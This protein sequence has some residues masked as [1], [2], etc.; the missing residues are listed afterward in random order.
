MKY[1]CTKLCDANIVINFI[2]YEPF[3]FSGTWYAVTGIVLGCLAFVVGMTVV[4]YK[5]YRKYGGQRGRRE[6]QNRLSSAIKKGLKEQNNSSM[7]KSPSLKSTGSARSGAGRG[8]ISGPPV[9]Q[10]SGKNKLIITTLCTCPVCIM[11]Y[12][13]RQCSS[14]KGFVCV[15]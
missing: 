4:A 12:N 7:K 6:G 2:Q 15:F 10:V 13:N 11:Q 9:I 1:I 14:V 8:S 5:C 3:I